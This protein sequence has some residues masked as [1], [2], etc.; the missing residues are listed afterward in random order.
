MGLEGWIRLHFFSAIMLAACLLHA[1]EEKPR[2]WTLNGYAKSLQ[3]V[4]NV[5]GFDSYL[6]DNLIHNRLNWKWYPSDAFVVR[7]EVRNRLFYGDLVKL[8]P[9]YGDQID[10]ENRDRFDLSHN[11]INQDDIVLNSNIDRAYIEW[12]KNDW[13]I[14]IG[15]QR[16]NWGINTVW[17]PNDVFNAFSFTD[18]DYE[19]RPG[20]DALR[21]K[22]YTGIASSVEF[23]I[24]AA[25]TWE[26]RVAAALFK[27]N[28]WNYD[29]QLLTGWASNEFLLGGGWAGNIKNSGFKGEWTFFIPNQKDGTSSFALTTAFDHSFQNSLYLNVGYLYNSNGDTAGSLG[30][31]FSFEL[32]AKNLYPFRHALFLMN[33]YPVTP[34]LNA[35]LTWIYSPVSS[36]PLFVNPGMTLSIAQSWDLDLI[37]QLAFNKEDTK[38]T[39]PVLAFFLRTKF[40]F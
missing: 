23:A 21:V 4:F 29:F 37:G 14:R 1:Q 10:L 18:F 35:S 26:E 31:I 30:E 12:N 27:W 2:N 36:H 38:Y 6:I 34:L 7:L 22:Y 15:R 9:A 3:T 11:W 5:D 33:S 20:T 28:A 17:N 32:S 16:I 39:S 40:S 8:T 24:S 19:E 25:K 13:E